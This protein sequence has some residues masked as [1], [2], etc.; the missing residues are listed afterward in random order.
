MK[1]TPQLLQHFKSTW[2]CGV[3]PMIVE[4]RP[5]ALEHI[6]PS[7]SL[8]MGGRFVAHTLRSAGIGPGDV[9]VFS[10]TSAI[11]W[12]QTFVGCLRLGAT[13]VCGVPS[14][15]REVRAALDDQ[16]ILRAVRPEP[17]VSELSFDQTSAMA[18]SLPVW[19][20]DSA[21]GAS[22]EGDCPPLCFLVVPV[23][24]MHRKPFGL[25]MIRSLARGAEIHVLHERRAYPIGA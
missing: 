12:T 14:A 23:K 11:S 1:S 7:P 10:G 16:L 6:C 8:W 18:R 19:E 22:V 17:N 2:L 4:H 21:R 9:V 13:M 15:F 3:M 20:G 5:G 25:E 24:A